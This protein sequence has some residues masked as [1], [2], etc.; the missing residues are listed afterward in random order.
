MTERTG[1]LNQL[2]A[3]AN[4]AI[5]PNIPAAPPQA[6]K[7]NGVLDTTIYTS[8]HKNWTNQQID[9]WLKHLE[10]SRA[11]SGG[12]FNNC[13]EDPNVV[14]DGA[15][16]GR[17]IAWDEFDADLDSTIV[18][19]S[20]T[21]RQTIAADTLDLGTDNTHYVYVDRAD[22]TVKA[23]TTNT[24]VFGGAPMAR[25]VTAGGNITSITPLDRLP[26]QTDRLQTI[27]VGINAN[28]L[29]LQSALIYAKAL[30]DLLTGTA[31]LTV[32]LTSDETI[33]AALS[34]ANGELFDNLT[35]DLNGNL[36]TQD[37]ADNCFTLDDDI[38]GL[39]IRNGRV[40]M[41][42][43]SAGDFLASGDVAK[44]ING[45]T[46]E[47]IVAVNDASQK[48]ARFVYFVNTT[49]AGRTVARA[50]ICDCRTWTTT[51]AVRMNTQTSDTF[52]DIDVKR[53]SFR[54][55][56]ATGA[57]VAVEFNRIAGLGTI[58]RVNLERV[59][60]FGSAGAIGILLQGDFHEVRH[61][62]VTDW[63]DGG[64]GISVDGNSI[65]VAENIVDG[66]GVA[67]NARGIL[68]DASRSS[69]TGNIIVNVT[70]GTTIGVDSSGGSNNVITGNNCGGANT[71]ISPAGSDE[72]GTTGAVSPGCN[73]A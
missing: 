35:I 32:K 64:D 23:S 68:C 18:G 34:V 69:I 43:A 37:G 33:S 56:N 24:A 13:A 73:K 1:F 21:R 63:A 4:A 71:A 47:K 59:K 11:P 9:Q 16:T 14:D 3:W 12:R 61:G 54:R 60:V 53:C 66:T 5:A 15:G 36:L 31:A 57:E 52:E 50:T 55:V 26:T 8:A 41:T 7:D 67:G 72:V 48:M 39:T 44:T 25:V 2:A 22:N 46:I 10:E 49:G 42:N 51:A 45:L 29:T 62:Y 38:D 40:I 30:S 27:T 20:A 58:D 70:G 17:V 19:K 65:Q 6:T 28:F